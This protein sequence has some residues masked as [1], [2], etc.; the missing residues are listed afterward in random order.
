MN[1]DSESL[2]VVGSIGSSGEVTQVELDLIPAFVQT[3]GHCA[4]EGFHSGR[5]LV[6][7]SSE[8]TSHVLVIQHLHFEG[9]VLL[10]LKSIRLSYCLHS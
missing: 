8:A 7:R 5:A 4:D 9:E 10:E 1:L 3:H 2:N 6:V